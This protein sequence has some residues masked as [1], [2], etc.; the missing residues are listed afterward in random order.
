MFKQDFIRQLNYIFNKECF[1]Q[2]RFSILSQIFDMLQG[3]KSVGNIRYFEFTTKTRYETYFDIMAIF[4]DNEIFSSQYEITEDIYTKD[5]VK[6][7]E[8]GS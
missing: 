1:Y 2:N 8:I 6:I 7:K 4:P 5:L 3:M